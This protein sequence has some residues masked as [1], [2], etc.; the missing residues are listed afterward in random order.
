MKLSRAASIVALSA[1]VQAS[2]AQ[3]DDVSAQYQDIFDTNKDSVVHYEGGDKDYYIVSNDR[4]ECSFATEN[5]TGQEVTCQDLKASSLLSIRFN[6]LDKVEIMQR[7][8][9]DYADAY[10]EENHRAVLLAQA[11]EAR[12]Q[13]FSQCEK[14]NAELK[15]VIF[16]LFEKG[17]L[18]PLWPVPDEENVG[19]DQS[20][21]RVF[22]SSP[23]ENGAVGSQAPSVAF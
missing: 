2:S 17:G 21:K 14:D 23:V 4:Y 18:I 12:N 10:D 13:E 19:K 9:S 7:V 20:K 15:Q 16:E 6:S 3:N 11:L 5:M 8:L 1:F 22:I